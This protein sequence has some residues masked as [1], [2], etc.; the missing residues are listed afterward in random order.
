MSNPQGGPPPPPD[1]QQHQ[2]GWPQQGNQQGWQG[3]PQ[4]GQQGWP[5]QQPQQ[6]QPQQ[7][8][9]PQQGNQQGWQQQGYPQGDQQSGQQGWPQQS[10]QG[11]P[12]QQSQQGWQQQGQQG[13]P[14]YAP[15]Q[16]KA[17][18]FIGTSVGDF[19]RDGVALVALFSTLTMPW[20]LQND[21][22]D[23]WWVIIAVLVSIASLAVPYVVKAGA[24]PGWG[25]AQS[26][27]VKLGLNVPAFLSVFGAIIFE[28]INAGKDFEGGIGS[29][30]AMLTA[31]AFL[32]ITPRAADDDPSGQSDK[33]WVL[34][35]QITAIGGPALML[36]GFLGYTF[37]VDLLDTFMVFLSALVLFVAIPAVSL[38][39]PAIGM[40][41]GQVGPRRVFATVAT[42]MLVA[43]L[44]ALASDRDSLFAPDPTGVFFGSKWN[45]PFFGFFLVGAAAALAASLPLQRLTARREDEVTGWIN[46]AKSA[47]LVGAALQVCWLLALLFNGIEYD[48]E[49]AMIISMVLMAISA[50]AAVGAF[51]F[52][53]DVRRNQT[54]IF[55][56][57]GVYVLLSI[58]TTSILN[59]E[60]LITGL[61][62]STLAMWYVLP[63][64]A[65]YALLVPRAVRQALPVNFGTQQQGYQQQGYPQQYQ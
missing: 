32:A 64:L 46:T 37:E 45:W 20:D 40:M 2:Q 21:A 19:I 53:S 63:G 36:V 26:R 1:P 6:N 51:T 65:A 8:G 33:T 22:N 23:R 56:A 29:G 34:L 39:W 16:P 42:S 3:Y 38:V 30:V 35:A 10:Q 31:G 59:S 4:G 60:D 50:A 57:L 5:Q 11:W 13:Y 28:L 55:I 43:N 25:P 12:Q 47:M 49:A 58:V 15:A 54:M 9:W 41:T 17:N 27:L 48:L 52:L 62:G 44:F 18:P 14:G 7:G 61:D 24:V